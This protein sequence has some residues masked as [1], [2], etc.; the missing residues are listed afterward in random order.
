M[1]DK[2]KK[3]PRKVVVTKKEEV[4]LPEPPRVEKGEIAMRM[5]Y[6]T[7]NSRDVIA[8]SMTEVMIR[9]QNQARSD[10]FDFGNGE[11]IVSWE[12]VA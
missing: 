9:A 4:T 3:Q 6:K 8:K 1:P 7:G 11:H 2:P 5:V 12:R 10:G